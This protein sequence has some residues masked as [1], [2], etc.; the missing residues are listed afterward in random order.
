M[1]RII[2]PLVIVLIVAATLF[3]TWN[4]YFY[5]FDSQVRVGTIVMTVVLSAF[6]GWAVGFFMGLS[7]GRRGRKA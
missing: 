6:L 4:V 1:N 7:Q 3:F 2:I 5:F